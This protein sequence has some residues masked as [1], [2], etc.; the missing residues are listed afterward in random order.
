MVG[1]RQVAGLGRLSACGRKAIASMRI[2]PVLRERPRSSIASLVPHRGPSS[3][4]LLLDP[5]SGQPYSPAHGRH[6]RPK[7]LPICGLCPENADSALEARPACG[8]RGEAF[9]FDDTI[10]H[11]AWNRSDQDR[12]V[13]IIDTWN[14]HLSAHEREMICRFYQAAD[15]QRGM[16]FFSAASRTASSAGM[17]IRPPSPSSTRTDWPSLISPA[18]ILSASGSCRYFW[19]AQ[20]ERP[21]AVDGIVADPAEPGARGVR[22]LD[23]NLAVLQQLEAARPGCSRSVPCAPRSDGGTG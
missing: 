2:A 1:T 4:G 15:E 8:E 12:A 21:G 23:A 5:E 7:H 20:L 19:I 22:E 18:R 13:L 16:V 3:R 17:I 11:E 10:E 14:P 9:V 6:Q